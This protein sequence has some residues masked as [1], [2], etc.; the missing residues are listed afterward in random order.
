[1]TQRPGEDRLIVLHIGLPKTGTTFL[2]HRVFSRAPELTLIHR[3]VT[4]EWERLCYDLRR[5][6]RYPGLI[7]PFF[8][9][10]VVAGLTAAAATA[11]GTLLLSDENVGVD[12]HSL[13]R[14]RG[15]S[16]ET[17]AKRLAVLSETIAPIGR[18]RVLIGVR[19][20]DTWLASRYAE[21]SRYYPKFNQIDFDR[22][23]ARAHA[24][25]ELSGPWR[26]TD[27]ALVEQ[28]FAARL[29]A[30]NIRLFSLEQMAA[31]PVLSLRALGTFLGASL[32]RPPAGKRKKRNVRAISE[33]AWRM[34]GGATLH[35]TTDVHDMILERYAASNAALS[36]R[37]ELGL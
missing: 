4:P 26:W 3:R 32:P 35:L 14:D 11:P 37:D 31:R 13:W 17:I 18:L 8:R 23:M 20:Q 10:R 6:G 28:A 2:Q 19:R 34:Q 24:A 15:P 33:N 36:G 21:S 29:G 22:R 30:E 12:A 9:R 5:Y 1:M 16:P 25:R 27:Y 7:A